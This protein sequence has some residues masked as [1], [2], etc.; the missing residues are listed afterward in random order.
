MMMKRNLK[1]MMAAAMMAAVVAV[2]A[3]CSGS[4]GSGAQEE[5]AQSGGTQESST[6]GSVAQEGDGQLKVGIIQ[7]IENGAFNDMREGFIQELRDQGYSEDRLVIDYKCAQGDTSNLQ[8]IAQGMA[9]GS[10]DLVA[11]IATPATQAM[12]N[13]ESDT[14]VIFVAVS[15]P[16]QAGVISDM[17]KPDKNATGTPSRWKTSLNLG[18]S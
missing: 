18:R 6:Q 10:Y 14:P 3:G 2:S 16:V 9:D 13:L 17:E 15:A 7:L 8:T 1:M 12:V 11:T 4:Q 5:S